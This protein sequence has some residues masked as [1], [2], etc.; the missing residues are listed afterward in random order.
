MDS[1]FVIDGENKVEV[2]EFALIFSKHKNLKVLFSQTLNQ[3]LLYQTLGGNQSHVKAFLHK[4]PFQVLIG[5]FWRDVDIPAFHVWIGKDIP[6][7]TFHA[8]GMFDD[9]LKMFGL[10]YE[11]Q[12]LSDYRYRIHLIHPSY[13]EVPH[14]LEL[15]PIL[16]DRAAEGCPQIAIDHKVIHLSPTNNLRIGLRQEYP[17]FVN[18]QKIRNAFSSPSVNFILSNTSYSN[19]KTKVELFGGNGSW[20]RP[21]SCLLSEMPKSKMIS[22]I[23]SEKKFLFGHRLRHN[24]IEKFANAFDIDVMGRAFHKIDKKEEGHLNYR[25]SIVIENE[26]NPYWFTEKLV[27]CL[28]CGCVPLYWGAPNVCDF[29]SMDSILTWS[30]LDELESLLKRCSSIDFEKRASSIQDNIYLA[31]SRSTIGCCIA[32][33]TSLIWKLELQT[34][35]NDRK[36]R[37]SE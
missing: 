18:Q 19:P 30:T 11:K 8:I 32:L 35:K 3:L 27:D 17:S 31:M 23:A 1:I 10:C 26:K 13:A 4:N 22:I 21:K 6:S 25:Y 7:G 15:S 2:Q 34:K 37:S 16:F 12:D 36:E 28:R 14:G 20:A 5:S 29:F 9:V 24:V 33:D